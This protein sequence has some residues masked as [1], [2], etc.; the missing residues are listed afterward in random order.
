M[1]IR[2]GHSIVVFLCLSATS[3]PIVGQSPSRKP[4]DSKMPIEASVCQ[5]VANPGKF[6]NKLARISGYLVISF[7]YSVLASDNCD[8]GIWFVLGGHEP[9][10]GLVITVNPPKSPK[11]SGRNKARLPITLAEDSSYK[12]LIAWLARSAKGEACLDRTPE[13]NEIPD[14]R[15]YRVS[16]TFTGRID[17]SRSNDATG[18]GHMGMFKAQLVVQRVENVQAVDRA[19]PKSGKGS[20]EPDKPAEKPEDQRDRRDVFSSLCP[21]H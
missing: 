3:F 7:E 8:D 17:G 16:A 11:D 21:A 13:P 2:L 14:C 5:V 15:T 9:V 10:P 18:F 4:I 20:S 1:R 19:N 12:E 6:D